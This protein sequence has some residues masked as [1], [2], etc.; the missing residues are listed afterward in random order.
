MDRLQK[1][2][3]ISFLLLFC[4]FSFCQAGGTEDLPADGSAEDTVREISQWNRD[5]FSPSV[6]ISSAET[7]KEIS[8]GKYHSTTQELLRTYRDTGSID[9]LYTAL[10]SA[11]KAVS[12]VPED[13]DLWTALGDLHA[14][15]KAYN[16]PRARE[17]A[18]RCYE[19]ALE[20]APGSSSVMILLAVNAAEMG[21]YDESIEYFEKALIKDL[22]LASG[23]TL[24]WM[25]QSYIQG[26]QTLRGTLFMEDL[27]KKEPDLS[28]LRI[29][30]ALL[31][32]SHFDHDSAVRELD[33]LIRDKNVAPP[34]RALAK[35]LKQDLS[36]EITR[37]GN[38]K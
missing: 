31:Y 12:F 5:M 30:K 6:E 15:L 16:M 1:F 13:P 36:L 20:L 18:I 23:N 37:T 21:L 19:K 10:N 22:S 29:F 7:D 26:R 2:R 8:A 27:L 9:D 34:L 11:G 25:T 38:R 4:Q 17:R 3:T 14:E 28:Y 32:A 24:Q 35:E 33:T